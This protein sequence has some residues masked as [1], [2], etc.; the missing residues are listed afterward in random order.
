MIEIKNLNKYYGKHQAINNLSFIIKKNEIV[1]FLGPNG[2]GKTTTL[3]IITGYINQSSGDVFINN[4]PN[5]KLNTKKLIG[6][7]PDT[8]P[9]YP[10]MKVKEYLNFVCELKSAKKNNLNNIM[11]KLKITDVKNKLIKTLSKGYKQR[12]GFAQAL[13]GD[14]EI[15]ILD[16]P[17]SGLDPKQIIE[18]RDL[19][20]SLKQ[21]HTILISSHILSEI[22]AI[23]DRVIIINKGQI[24]ADD[25]PKELYKNLIHDKKIIARLKGDY[26]SILALLYKNNYNLECVDYKKNIEDGTIDMIFIKKHDSDSDLDLNLNAKED[27][28]AI[29]IREKIFLFAKENNLILL[30]MKPFDISLEEIFLK[31][32]S[33]QDIQD[34]QENINKD[35]DLGLDS[36][37]NSNNSNQ[38]NKKEEV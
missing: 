32:T 12:V 6:Y 14:P 34:D 36:N 21:E 3:N 15:L 9:L 37:F 26:E 38:E 4:K 20:K 33:D 7:L 31:L 30:M 19:I 11:Q 17:I 13:I 18:M 28:K 24:V 8:P 1:G 10:D 29:D 35:F 27:I 5:Y 22:N 25:A 23:A 16:E 2:A